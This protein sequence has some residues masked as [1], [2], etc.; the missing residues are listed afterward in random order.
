MTRFTALQARRNFGAVLKAADDGFV[1]ISKRGRD[2]YV[3][4]PMWAFRT[5][6]RIREANVAGRIAVTTETALAKFRA[7]DDAA[8]LT[9]IRESNSLMKKLLDDIKSRR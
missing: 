4:M 6:E 1:I 8:G 5:Y 9:I 3:L 2:G 7:G